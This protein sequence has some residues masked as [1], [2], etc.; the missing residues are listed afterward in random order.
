MEKNKFNPNNAVMANGNIF[1]FPGNVDEADIVLIPVPW[2]ATTSHGKGSSNGPQA[3]LQASIQLDFF[4]HELDRA[5]E[6]KVYM[7]EISSEWKK[8]NNG[9]S[10]KST[11]YIR[12]L[13]QEGEEKAL[14]YFKNEIEHINHIQSILTSNLKDRCTELLEKHKIVG[15]IGGEHS[16]SLGLIQALNDKFENFGILQ[17]DAHADL[18][19]SYLGFDQSHASSMRN[20]L[21]TCPQMTKLVQMG[22]R[23]LSEEEYNYAE[24]DQRISTYYDWNIK[25]D[26]LKG[27]LWNDSVGEIIDELP[28]DIYISFDIDGLKPFLCPNTGTPVAGGFELHEI[29]LLFSEIEA[30]GKNIIGFD[31]CEV[32][33]GDDNQIDANFGAQTLWEMVCYAEKSRR[34]NKK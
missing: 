14:G 32:S 10:E 13:E 5:Y 3:I 12:Y 9:C 1:G 8:I 7:T 16:T 24:N 26:I 23:D 11:E 31:L 29:Q 4:H 30:S 22:V 17:I 25:K 28:N 21:S 19:D 27:R 34:R 33:P 6:T 2:D 18:K 20:V 15:I